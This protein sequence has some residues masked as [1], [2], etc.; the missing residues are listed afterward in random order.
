[1]AGIKEDG[2]FTTFFTRLYFKPI[3]CFSAQ[4][5]TNCFYFRGWILSYLPFITAEL[6]YPKSTTNFVSLDAICC[7]TRRYLGDGDDERKLERSFLPGWTLVADLPHV[8]AD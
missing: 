4:K 6:N 7:Y 8:G 1:M 3:C 2:L 5:R